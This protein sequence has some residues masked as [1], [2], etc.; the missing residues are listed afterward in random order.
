MSA[1][2]TTVVTAS[3]ERSR[4]RQPAG[5]SAQ[6]R[7]RWVEL[8][9]QIED[10]RSRYYLKDAPTIGDDEYDALFRELV[11]LGG[12]EPGT[13]HGGFTDADSRWCRAEMFEPVEHLV[14]M[15][16]L[17][18]AFGVEELRA[19]AARVEKDLGS[20]PN[21]LCELKVDGLA[22]DLGSRE[23]ISAHWPPVGTGASAKT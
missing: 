6:L 14:R 16:S 22:V 7:Q 13:R 3:G 8:V 18:N 9:E 1:S 4:C 11:E 5:P 10:A 17:D 2:L 19:W 20:I 12:D 23:E 15:M 21:L